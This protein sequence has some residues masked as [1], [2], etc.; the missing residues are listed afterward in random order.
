MNR[1]TFYIGCSCSLNQCCYEC[2]DKSTCFVNNF[3]DT[4]SILSNS[5]TLDENSR[6]PRKSVTFDDSVTIITYVPREKR[7][8]GVFRVPR[9]YRR[10]MG[11]QEE[12]GRKLT[13]RK[14]LNNLYL[15]HLGQS[16]ES[17]YCNSQ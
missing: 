5:S 11:K 15:K 7:S 2:C 12:N 1:P 17:L 16:V 3:P 6:K 13:W 9:V 4:S 8:E 10:K 14:K